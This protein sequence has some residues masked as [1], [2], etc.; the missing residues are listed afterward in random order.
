M[1]SQIKL[2]TSDNEEFSVDRDVAERSVLIKN[3][4]EG[5]CMLIRPLLTSHRSWNSHELSD[6]GEN[7]HP[8]PL[9]NVSATVLAK[10]CPIGII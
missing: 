7:E 2:T 9:P 1:P 5:P 4:L 3:M 6:V 10:V 8:I